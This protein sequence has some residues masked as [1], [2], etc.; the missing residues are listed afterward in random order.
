MNGSGGSVHVGAGCVRRGRTRVCHA[1]ARTITNARRIG[2]RLQ[3]KCASTHRHARVNVDNTIEKGERTGSLVRQVAQAMEERL[4][5]DRQELE[6]RE[7]Q[8]NVE[9]A[10]R[11]CGV[12]HENDKKD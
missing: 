8:R 9:D 6:T 7:Q 5:E 12:V 2:V 1:S 4:K 3:S 11:T 10:K